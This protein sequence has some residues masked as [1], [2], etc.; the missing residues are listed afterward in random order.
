MLYAKD[1][2][3]CKVV[4]DKGNRFNKGKLC[5]RGLNVLEMLYHPQRLLYPQV[6]AGKRG[7]NRWSKI[8]W[9]E[10]LSITADKFNRIKAEYGAESVIFCKGTA[11]DIGAWIT[12][13]CYGFGSPNYFGFGPANG[14]A[15][16]RPRTAVSTVVLGSVPVPDIGQFDY[17]ETGG[18]RPPKCLLIWGANPVHTNPDGI[19]G[20]NVIDLMNAGTDLIVIDPQKT[21]LASKAK[22]YLQVK[23]GTDA[24]LAL[25]IL[26][27]VIDRNLFDREYCDNRILGFAELRNAVKDYP[28]DKVSEIT[29]V[30]AEIIEKAALFFAENSPAGVF[31]GV[32]VD[33]H[34]DC[35]GII[36]ALIALMAVTGN[37][38]IPGGW[39]FP[40]EPLGV[41]RR[42]DN[43]DDFPEITRRPIGWEEYPLTAIGNPY[44]QP[45]VLLKQMETGLPYPIKG[46]WIQGAGIV[47]S[48]FA[49]PEKA[50][51]LFRKLIFIA[52]TDVFINPAMAAFAD[53][54]FPAAMYT[55]KD[56]IYVHNCQLGAIIKAVKPPGECKSDAEINLLLGKRIAPKYF[57]WDDVRGWIDYRLKPAGLDFDRLKELGSI[58]PKISSAIYKPPFQ[59]PSGK[60]ELYSTLLE[61][62]GLPPLPYYQD[63]YEYFSAEQKANHPYILTTGARKPYFFGAEQRNSPSSRKIQREPEVTIHP[64]TAAQKGITAGD[65]VKIYSPFGSCYMTAKISENYRQE[66]IHCDSGWWYPE[67]EGAEP[68]L[69]G[70]REANVN[71]LFPAGLQGKSGLGYPFRSF[72]CN[73][74]KAG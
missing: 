43:I 8:S 39:V 69:F 51:E 30:S 48:G 50:I 49:E 52:F 74:E 54:I 45:D 59:T 36:Q 71:N 62:M 70:L 13:L 47:P 20:G 24:A 40:G 32:A 11:R 22:Y 2:K 19:F 3:L 72:I 33:M 66:V 16:Y 15:C 73:V 12:R 23:P 46:A 31:W 38:G 63:P 26:K 34:R 27:V 17:S 37:I 60:I 29:G 58:V 25:G 55:E 28:L 53:I 21:G 68:E 14:N 41:A 6:R 5:I 10:A 1:G 44:G 18:F 7:E 64:S 61:K 42:G 56:S 4:G 57:P 65:R 67:R 35:I 9:E